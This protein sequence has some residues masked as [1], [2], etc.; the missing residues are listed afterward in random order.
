MRLHN[1]VVSLSGC[2]AI[3]VTGMLIATAVDGVRRRVVIAPPMLRA[4]IVPAKRRLEPRLVLPAEQVGFVWGHLAWATARCGGHVDPAFARDARAS[5]ARNPK[6]FATAV[7]AGRDD[8]AQAVAHFGV[9]SVCA[10]AVSMYGKGGQQMRGTYL[11]PDVPNP[12]AR[13]PAAASEKS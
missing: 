8:V 6:V 3:V 9:S 4:G 12:V 5:Y 10:V 7:I 13:Q 1:K 2:A 11:E